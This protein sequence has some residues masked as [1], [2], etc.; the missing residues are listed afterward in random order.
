M[1]PQQLKQVADQTIPPAQNKFIQIKKRYSTGDIVN[2]VLECYRQSS[3]QVKALAPYLKG[4]NVKD[5]CKNI[6]N[7]L[8]ENVKY[9]IDPEDVQWVKEPAKVWQDKRCDCKSYSIFIASLLKGLDI[10]GCFRFVSYDK[11]PNPTHVYVVVRNQGEDII[12]DDVMPAFNRQ[13]PYES[14]K[15]YSM[16]GLYRVS[17]LPAASEKKPRI[18]ALPVVGCCDSVGSFGPDPANKGKFT[19]KATRAGMGVQE[20]AKYVLAHKTAY[21]V[22]TIREA[23]WARNAKTKFNH[24]N[25]LPVVGNYG[26][27]INGLFD[28]ISRAVKKTL[29]TGSADKYLIQLAP[30]LLYRYIPSHFL[31]FAGPDVTAFFQSLPSLVQQKS[32]NCDDLLNFMHDKWGQDNYHIGHTLHHT[33]MANLGMEPQTYLALV[34]GSQISG[35][36]NTTST[37]VGAIN[38]ATTAATTGAGAAAGGPAAPITAAAAFITS[39]VVGISQVELPDG[40]KIQNIAPAPGDWAGYPT[41]LP[42][43]VV[44]PT[45]A[46]PLGAGINNGLYDSNG[47]PLPQAT[48]QNDIPVVDQTGDI[49][50]NPTTKKAGISPL[51][52][53]GLAGAAIAMIIGSKKK[54]KGAKR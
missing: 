32:H 12:I 53:I 35:Y 33:L 27:V 11:D 10:K 16:T 52:G 42:T 5:T 34:I 4:D 23:V 26:P 20:F 36:T 45:N 9:K 13:K 54:K 48:Q 8:K 7:F 24:V 51:L 29:D 28:N 6:W 22:T 44:A 31:K 46:D 30:A 18:T 14:K 41:R 38:W 39:L 3:W 50:N 21:P 2:E 15:D 17:G 47:N 25:G 40:F 19:A 43:F 37:A 1:T 49:V